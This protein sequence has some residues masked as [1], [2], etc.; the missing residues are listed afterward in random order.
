LHHGAGLILFLREGRR[1]LFEL[2]CLAL[3]LGLAYLEC[4]F[5]AEQF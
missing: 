3:A 2:V 1:A 4:G 5:T